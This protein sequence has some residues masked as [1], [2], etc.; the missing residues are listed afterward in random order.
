M[1]YT[2][3]VVFIYNGDTME[4]H[5]SPTATYAEQSVFV[6]VVS[7]NMFAD[8]NYLPLLRDIMFDYTLALYFTD[9]DFNALGITN[10]DEFDEFNK[11]TGIMEDV[12][13][14][15]SSTMLTSLAASVDANIEYKKQTAQN[16]ISTAVAE[17]IMALTNKVEA[18]DTNLDMSKVMD[19]IN[20]FNESGFDGESLVDAYM[21]SEQYKKNVAEVVDAK[22]EKIRELQQ[23]VN[24]ETAKNVVADKKP[25]KKATAKSAVKTK[26]AESES[27]IEVVKG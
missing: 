16:D 19:F 17:L 7:N 11:A 25:A 27:K 24:D 20:K 9:I 8:G 6:S 18:L 15:L 10:I 2:E 23:R 5:V 14:K 26:K 22:N 3:K 1:N 13:D 12:R 21:N 4:C